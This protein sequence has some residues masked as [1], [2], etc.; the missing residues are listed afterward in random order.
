MR[1]LA[2]GDSLTAGYDRYGTAHHPYSLR[3]SELISSLG[4]DVTIDQQGWC[5]ELVVSS[6]VRRLKNVLSKNNSPP[7]DWVIILGGTNDLGWKRADGSIFHEGLKLMYER[8]LQQDP[9]VQ[10]VVMTVIE[11]EPYPPEHR[12]DRPRQELNELIRSYTNDHA[13]KDQRV[14]LVDL[15]KEIRYHHVDDFERRDAI[16]DDGVH[17]T[18]IGYD[19]MA[20]IIFR[21]IPNH[22][23]AQNKNDSEKD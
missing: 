21:T 22:L 13:G 14:H 11:V 7:Y 6:M 5:G 8:V 10:L 1:I 15:A 20:D 12:Q 16:W 9:R 19:I 4:I 3:L 18:P 17:L 23:S 2:F